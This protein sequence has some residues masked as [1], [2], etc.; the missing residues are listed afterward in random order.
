MS[1]N[2]EIRNSF[3]LGNLF[4]IHNV[5]VNSTVKTFLEIVS[6]KM[7]VMTNLDS[8]GKMEHVNSDSFKY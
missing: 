3:F 1:V 8:G 4:K 7:I 5:V 6:Q 2:Y